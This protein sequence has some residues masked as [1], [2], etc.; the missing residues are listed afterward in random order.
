MEK[1]SDVIFDLVLNER[2]ELVARGARVRRGNYRGFQ[3]PN[4]KSG[5]STRNA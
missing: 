3:E 2:L 1:N 5:N 4:N